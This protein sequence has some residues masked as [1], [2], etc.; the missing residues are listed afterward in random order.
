[1]KENKV[2]ISGFTLVE[3]MIVIGIIGILSVLAIPSYQS[4]LEGVRRVEAKANLMELSGFMERFYTENSQYNQ[5]RA[6]SA[7]AVSLPVITSDSYTY[8]L[9]SVG[10]TAYTLQAVPQ[11]EQATDSCGTMKITNTN[12]KTPVTD[13]CW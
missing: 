6:A 3:L 12:V 11:G 13:G 7:A 4:H 1:M 2:N 9:F 10:E 5:T 8:S